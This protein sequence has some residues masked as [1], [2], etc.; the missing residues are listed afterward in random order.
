MKN[1]KDIFMV[2]VTKLEGLN[3]IIIKRKKKKEKK[4][5]RHG[6]RKR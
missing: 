3:G 5:G 6:R 1:L 2:L 4:E